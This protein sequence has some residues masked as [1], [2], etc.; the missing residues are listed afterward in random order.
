MLEAAALLERNVHLP[1]TLHGGDWAVRVTQDELGVVEYRKR[2]GY[3]E[4]VLDC[5]VAQTAGNAL[6]MIAMAYRKGYNAG[7]EAG[8][9]HRRDR[10]AAALAG[11]DSD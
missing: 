1:A 7:F 11:E 6:D 5:V 9:K 2:W 3:M 10:I 8:D 4:V